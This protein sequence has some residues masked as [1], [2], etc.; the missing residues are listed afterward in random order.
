MRKESV[1]QEHL[2]ASKVI[3]P[4]SHRG[5]TAYCDPIPGKARF[6]DPGAE[7][8]AG[9][10]ARLLRR[11]RGSEKSRVY[12]ICVKKTI[13]VTSHFLDGLPVRQP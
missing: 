5:E 2:V 4:F 7:N 8:P 3:T 9:T 10:L 1:R 13:F 12:L 6:V 11:R